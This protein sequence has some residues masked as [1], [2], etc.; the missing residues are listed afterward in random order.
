MFKV[1]RVPEKLFSVV[2]WI[3]SLVFAGFLM[4]LGQLVIG[5]LPLATAPVT[6]EQFIDPQQLAMVT[7][8]RAALDA[9]GEALT[10]RSDA[11]ELRTQTARREY[12]A[13]K[14]QYDNWLSTR[15]AT[16]D[17]AQD[18]EVVERTRT[19]DTL[20]AAVREAQK[21]DEA[22]SAERLRHRPGV[23][24]QCGPARGARKFSARNL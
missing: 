10:P 12:D 15:V 24:R 18:P 1:L 20:S 19:L 13:A 14:Q 5:D 4:G 11:V 23:R 17:P 22:I 2:M 6:I 8:E 9:K 7:A 16:T 21:G 3:V